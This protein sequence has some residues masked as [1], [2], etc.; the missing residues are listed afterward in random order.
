VAPE[1]G[2]TS[3]F[4]VLG[5]SKKYFLGSKTAYMPVFEPRN[6]KSYPMGTTSII[7]VPIP[8]SDEIVNTPPI[9]SARSLI[10]ANP[11]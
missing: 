3:F 10:P 4:P 1:I 2:A 11:K 9:A 8:G 5:M 6:T 7:D